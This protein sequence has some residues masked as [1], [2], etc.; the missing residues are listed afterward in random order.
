MFGGIGRA[1]KKAGKFAAQAV[2]QPVAGLYNAGVGAVQGDWDQAKMGLGQIGKG[3]LKLGALGGA[4]LAAPTV[5][6][7]FGGGGAAAAAGPV[8]DSAAMGAAPLLG[9]GATTAA[10]IAG[11]GKLAGLGKVAGQAGSWISQH[12]EL[13]TDIAG[14]GL[15][16]Y[17]AGQAGDMAQREF[18][19]QQKIQ[20]AELD[21]RLW[22]RKRQEQ[23][24]EE[25]RNRNAAM[26]P[27][28][29]QLLQQMIGQRPPTY[30]A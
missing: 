17:G 15:Q 21:E 23:L 16:A 27:I 6:G 7:L 24:D 13:A 25:K 1:L 3:G 9:T 22:E 26:D 30:G 28:R 20:Q 11:A 19:W 5:G 10:K 2:Y 14:L 4:Y 8:V 12:P 29:A 18:E